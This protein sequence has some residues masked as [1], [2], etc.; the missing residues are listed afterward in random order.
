MTSPIEC[1]RDTIQTAIKRPPVTEEKLEM[2]SGIRCRGTIQ[3]MNGLQK[4][5]IFYNSDKLNS[6]RRELLARRK[7]GAGRIEKVSFWFNKSNI[8]TIAVL[9]PLTLEVLI[10]NTIEPRITPGMQ[11]SQWSGRKTAK[12]KRD[13]RPYGTESETLDIVRKKYKAKLKKVRDDRPK[14]RT[15]PVK[16][17]KPRTAEDLDRLMNKGNERYTGNQPASQTSSDQHA[18]EKT[19]DKQRRRE[20]YKVE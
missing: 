13:S 12:K 5:N 10:V 8:H 18:G 3:E 16:E 14:S 9:N 19:E 17:G 4:Y 20:D 15:P 7:N 2:F 1:W 11:L 6:L